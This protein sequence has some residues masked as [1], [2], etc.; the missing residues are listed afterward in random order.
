[1]LPI[2]TGMYFTFFFFYVLYQNSNILCIF[3]EV[4]RRNHVKIEVNTPKFLYIKCFK[5]IPENNSCNQST[6]KRVV[7]LP[8]IHSYQVDSQTQTDEPTL[9]RPKRITKKIDRLQ[10]THL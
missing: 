8:K 1:M 4:A 5:N 10:Y 9:P 7:N 2:F 6:V 3:L